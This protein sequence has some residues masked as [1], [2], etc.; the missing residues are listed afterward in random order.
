M[1]NHQSREWD[2][3]RYCHPFLF[4]STYQKQAFHFLI[5]Y[6]KKKIQIINHAMAW[7]S[8]LIWRIF[9]DDLSFKISTELGDLNHSNFCISDDSGISKRGLEFQF[10]CYQKNLQRCKNLCWYLSKQI[11]R[12]SVDNLVSK[13]FWKYGDLNH[14]S[15]RNSAYFWLIKNGFKFKNWP[16]KKLIG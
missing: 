10:E 13:I 2:R 6:L 11:W 12:K 8:W 7:Y 14:S 3:N 1:K 5:S 4:I 15:F 16:A 9:Q